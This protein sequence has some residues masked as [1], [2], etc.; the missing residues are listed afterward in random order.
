MTKINKA[1]KE[2]VRIGKAII[3]VEEQLVEAEAKEQEQYETM[4]YRI[5]LMY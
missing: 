1:E 2:L 5:V 4:K 3:K